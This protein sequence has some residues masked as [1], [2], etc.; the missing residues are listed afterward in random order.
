MVRVDESSGDRGVART[1]SKMLGIVSP[2]EHGSPG[3]MVF[4]EPSVSRTLSV[5]VV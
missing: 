2:R 1:A 5:A 4:N 3:N